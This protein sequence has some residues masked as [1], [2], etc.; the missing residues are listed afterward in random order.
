M[1]EEILSHSCFRDITS[2]CL[3]CNFVHIPDFSY[4]QILVNFV[5]FLSLFALLYGIQV[6]VEMYV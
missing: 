5:H 3:Y 1:F 6:P 2:V 4:F